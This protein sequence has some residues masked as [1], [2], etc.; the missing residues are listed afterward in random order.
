[1]VLNQGACEEIF[2]RART[3]TC[4]TTIFERECVPF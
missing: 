2:R 4:S 3:R 1:V